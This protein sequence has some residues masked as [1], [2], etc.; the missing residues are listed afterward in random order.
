M[1]Q[2]SYGDAHGLY[3]VQIGLVGDDGYNYGTAERKWRMAPPQT[4][5]SFV[6]LLAAEMAMPDRT[7]ID[8][9]GGDVWTGSY[10]HGITSLGTFSLTLSTVDATLISI[11]TQIPG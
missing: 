2:I 3:R 9:T 7:V 1:S 8:F 10:V 11:V 5:M 6:S 4:L